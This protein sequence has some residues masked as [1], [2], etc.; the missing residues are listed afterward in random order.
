MKR[1][2]DFFF[3]FVSVINLNGDF[4]GIEKRGIYCRHIAEVF[5]LSE[6]EK[7]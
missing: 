6:G 4:L 3:L 1:E 2:A 7:C 5:A